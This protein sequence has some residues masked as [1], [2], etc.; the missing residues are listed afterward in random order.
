MKPKTSAKATADVSTNS[1]SWRRHHEPAGASPVRRP[2]PKDPSPL[3]R[4]CS[5]LTIFQ[6]GMDPRRPGVGCAVRTCESDGGSVHERAT[7]PWRRYGSPTFSSRPPRWRHSSPETMVTP[8]LSKYIALCP[9]TSL[10]PWDTKHA[11]KD[12]DLCAKH[13]LQA[14]CTSTSTAPPGTSEPSS[15]GSDRTVPACGAETGCSIF[16]ASRT[17]RSCPSSTS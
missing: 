9:K 13:G 4:G 14:S 10:V 8:G 5:F 16:I 15:N 17:R 3:R 11:T 12:H 7:I 2:V 1:R 6:S